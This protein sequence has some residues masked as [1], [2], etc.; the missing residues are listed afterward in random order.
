MTQFT[1][2]RTIKAFVNALDEIYGKDYKSLHIYSTLIGKIKID[3]KKNI[4][5]HVKLHEEFMRANQAQIG[6]KSLPLTMPIIEY[7]INA[8]I[9]LN[10]IMLQADV[11]NRDV[12]WSHLRNVAEAMGIVITNSNSALPTSDIMNKL[13]PAG[14][15][16][17][18]ELLRNLF[19]STESKMR[20]NPTTDM[21]SLIQTGMS[22]AFMGD[23]MNADPKKLLRTVKSMLANL[24]SIVGGDDEDDSERRNTALESVD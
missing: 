5:R 23:L 16:Q 18:N 4:E 21:N 20:A 17:E 7:S 6:S 3:M 14:N 12:I 1:I 15:S 9:P 13:L 10:I 2:F 11:N 22:S 24:D 8:N 19:T